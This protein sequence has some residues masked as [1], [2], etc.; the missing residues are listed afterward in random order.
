M[1]DGLISG[2][3]YALGYRYRQAG[4][5]RVKKVPNVEC[6]QVW[7]ESTKER[8]NEREILASSFRA[9]ERHI[10][11]VETPVVFITTHTH[12]LKNFN[13]RFTDIQAPRGFIKLK[14]CSRFNSV[15]V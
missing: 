13:R 5:E 12:T 7:K 2:Q 10:S 11:S 9:D 4:T 8:K 15:L 6:P 14:E 1:C 3:S